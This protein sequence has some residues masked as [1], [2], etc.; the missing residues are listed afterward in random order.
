LPVA[1]CFLSLG[2]AFSNAARAD[3]VAS[4]TKAGA[5]P[6]PTPARP[7]VVP[8]STV[9]RDPLPSATET[10]KEEHPVSNLPP[11]IPYEA[12]SPDYKVALTLDDAD[13][14]DFVR[15]IG[16]LT[17]RRF[18]IASVHAK[19]LKATLYAPE[20]VTVAEAYQ[21]F[22]AVLRANGLTVLPSGAF[23]KVVDTQD[24]AKQPTPVVRPGESVTGDDRYITC[25]LRLHHVGAEDVA[26]SVLSKLATKDGTI[27]PYAPGNLVILTDTG[28]NIRRMQRVLEDIDVAEAGDKVWIQP[29]HYLQATDIEKKLSEVFDLKAGASSGTKG[30]APSGADHLT[31]LV[32]LDRPN[33]LV[34]VGSEAAYMRVLAIVDRVDVP[35]LSEGAIHVVTLEHADAKKIVPAINEALA[36]ATSAAG[37]RAG[38]APEPVAILESP[39]KV[40]AEETT[41]SVLVTASEHD[42]AAVREV[43]AKLDKPRRQ[44]YIEAIVMDV[45]IER[46]STFGVQYH[47]LQALGGSGATLYGGMNPFASASQPTAAAASSVTDTTLQALALGIRGPTIEALGMSIPAFGALVQASTHTLDGDILQTPHILATDNI[48]AEFHVTVNRSLQQNAQ[49]Y[50][51]LSALGGTSAAGASPLL[52]TAPAAANYKPLGPQIKVTPHLNES[53]DVRLDVVET[54]SDTTGVTEGTL[55]TLPFTER[56]ATTTLTVHDQQTA[57]IGGLVADKVAHEAVKIPLL[58]DIP[59]F[60]ALFRHTSDTKEKTDLVLVLTPYIIRDQEDMRRIVERRMEERQE[61]LDHQLLFSGRP[62]HSPEVFARGGGLLIE[63]RKAQRLVDD[64]IDAKSVRVQLA[65]PHEPTV[66]IDLP[67]T[68]SPQ[69]PAS[70]PDKA[71]GGAV[72]VER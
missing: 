27:T 42:F 11:D 4:V 47:G 59:L 32:P 66:P 6:P 36:S 65:K 14:T 52:G 18:V 17:G 61:L 28:E 53:D 33:A 12:K 15:T 58:G 55:G 56:G 43:I 9:P 63:M 2:V 10:P 72:K 46:D 57:V 23:W 44:V 24:I 22:L 70:A 5:A 21:A 38:G 62:W 30:A 3:S 45:D 37:A 25:V 51:S 40:A 64:E 20:K 29:I 19:G 26:G 68:V 50:A 1:A 49:S 39:V 71:S 16:Q 8:A 7:A 41:N 60:G 69:A 31:R 48:Q 34:I 67:P 35:V 13:L 54:I